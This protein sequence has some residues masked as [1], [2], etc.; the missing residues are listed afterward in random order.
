MKHRNLFDRLNRKLLTHRAQRL[1]RDGGWE[2][3]ASQRT[4][5]LLDATG[6]VVAHRV[7]LAALG[8]ELFI[9]A[10]GEGL[11]P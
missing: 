1:S 4:Y 7:D 8:R 11:E 2:L 10:P 3:S 5:T 9:L 6:R